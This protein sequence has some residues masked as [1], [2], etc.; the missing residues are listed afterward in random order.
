M[1]VCVSML[2][3]CVCVCIHVSSLDLILKDKK[4]TEYF[5]QVSEELVYTIFQFHN[6]H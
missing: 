5:K 4:P 2:Y 6:H 1:C 3:V